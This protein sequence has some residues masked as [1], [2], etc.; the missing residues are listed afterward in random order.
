MRR[1]TRDNNL[2][3][4]KKIIYTALIPIDDPLDPYS[5]HTFLHDAVMLNRPELFDMLLSNGSNPMVRD[6]N[7]YTPLL[8]A[9]ALGRLDMVKKLVEECGVDPRH[10]DPFG[11]TPLEKAALY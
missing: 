2:H 7:G 10:I 1:L 4:L 9:A 8:K 3:E 11:V 5:Q 6:Q